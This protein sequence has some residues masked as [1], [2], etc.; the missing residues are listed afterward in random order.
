MIGK[1]T[2]FAPAVLLVAA[3]MSAFAG[4]AFGDAYKDLVGYDWGRSRL[5][6]TTIES[7]IRAAAT[8]AQRRIIEGKLLGVLADPKATPAC[9]QFVCRALRRAGSAACVPA[10]AKLLADAELSDMARFTLQHLEGAE[11]TEA[12]MAAAEKLRGDLRIGMVTSLGERRDARAVAI[13]AR[14]MAEGDVKQAR[15]AIRALG[16][17]AGSQAAEALGRA[18][19]AKGLATALADARLL[20]ADRMLAD[21]D[22]AAAGGVYEGLF[23]ERNPM[24][25][26]IAALRGIVRSK[27]EAAAGT[28]LALMSHREA[29]LRRAANRFVIELHGPA[30]TRAL[31][32]GLDSLPPAGQLVLLD[33]LSFRADP[34]AAPQVTSLVASKTEAVRLAAIRAL[35]V[36]GDAGSV[37]VLAK[38]AAGGGAVGEAAID[39]LN[40]LRGEGVSEA[41]GKLLDSGDPA[42]RAGILGVLAARADK[43]MTPV[44]LK[45]ARDSDRSVRAAAIKGLEVVAGKA[46]LPAL[47]ALLCEAKDPGDRAGVERAL[48]AAAMRVDNRQARTAPIVAALPGAPAAAKVPL[49]AV[50]G[51]L[52]G[53]RALPAV[54]AELTGPDAGVVTAA[55]RALHAW[56]DASAAPDLLGVIKDSKDPVRRALAFRGYV[57]MAAL[58]ELSGRQ[59]A[60][61]LRQAMGLASNAAEKKLLLGGLAAARSVEA[62]KLIEPLL[63]EAELKA[64]AQMAYIQIAGNIRD[65]APAE[66]RKALKRVI[67]GPANGAVG[68][69]AGEIL[70][71]LDKYTGFVISW[72]FSGPY[73]KGPLFET[74]YPPEKPGARGV[75]WKQLRKGVGP[76]VIDLAKAVGGDNRAVYLTASV[77]SPADQDVRLEIGSDDGVKVWVN[78]KGV[79]AND[80][81]RSLKIGQDRA[82][83]KLKKGWNRLLVKVTQGGG[84]WAFCLRVTRPDGGVLE[85]LRVSTENR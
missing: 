55:V 80:T 76:Q 27:K 29:D 32:A 58:G 40:R 52:G 26:R 43:T 73:S 41:M 21:G 68:R 83:A 70:G 51:R 20:C 34:A 74:A 44:M 79:H 53:K 3:V 56:P 17:V 1:R 78:G 84:D 49:I 60:R 50:L 4:A 16:R 14:L 54:R 30:A 18:K 82:A 71:E 61:M 10:M 11:A 65:A 59:S 37:P 19:V 23:T 35:A 24:P 47:V 67:A 64:E 39:S 81:S 33:A 7:E 13:L 6:L 31:A 66:A 45:A 8:P 36:V 12:L 22:A 62:L 38:A 25:I 72:L 85:G 5:P 77:L 42:F 28:L 57:R 75:Q 2:A 63:G 15:A 48:S 69:R 46:E 9:K